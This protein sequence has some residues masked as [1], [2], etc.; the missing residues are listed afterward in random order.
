MRSTSDATIDESCS[1]PVAHTIMPDKLDAEKG[2]FGIFGELW[3]NRTGQVWKEI[4]ICC[5]SYDALKKGRKERE[6][7]GGETCLLRALATSESVSYLSLCN[8]LLKV[9]SLKELTCI[10]SRFLSIRNPGIA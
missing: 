5:I 3:V 10:T 1:S 9:N 6:S 4:A 8:K 7:K 2:G